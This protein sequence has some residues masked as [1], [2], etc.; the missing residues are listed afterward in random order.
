MSLFVQPQG[1]IPPEKIQILEDLH[2]ALDGNKD[3][4]GE[5]LSRFGWTTVTAA[6]VRIVKR[7]CANMVVTST[8]EKSNKIDP[9][10]LAEKESSVEGKDPYYSVDLICPSCET[11]LTG[12]ILRQK[13]LLIVPEYKSK[14]YPLM[15]PQAVKPMGKYRLADPLVRQA[16]VCPDCLYA[17]TSASF[18]K[19]ESGSKGFIGNLT[20]K[21][22]SR[23]RE[24]MAEDQSLRDNIAGKY[25]ENDCAKWNFGAD[26]HVAAIAHVLAARTYQTLTDIDPRINFNAGEAHLAAAKLYADLEEQGEE[27]TH[28]FAAKSTFENAFQFSS[29][30]ALPLYLL[31][32]TSFH[33]GNA[34]E[35]RIWASRLLT[36]KRKLDGSSK[37]VVYMEN[38]VED[39]RKKIGG[40]SD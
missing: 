30:T 40:T 31:S 27:K 38:L 1:N 20:A 16:I 26:K 33:I 14:H 8:N 19:A 29:G 9:A 2:N 13:A 18:F 11:G 35:S 6:N 39:V 37:Y 36:Q 21:K 5:Y 34:Q 7:E 12:S 28:L 10:A 24:L 17:S 32:V 15:V 3:L 25:K 22:I 23:L 4:M